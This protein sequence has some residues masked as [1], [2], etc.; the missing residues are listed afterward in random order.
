M[1]TL[2]IRIAV[3]SGV[4]TIAAAT[5]AATPAPPRAALPQPAPPAEPDPQPPPPAEMYR[6]ECGSCHLAYP[7][8]LLPAASWRRL[9]GGLEEHFGDNAELDASAR[10]RL[11][12]WLTNNSAQ[13][14][15]DKRGRK[16]VRTL[17]EP[18]PLRVSQT[19]YILRKHKKVKDEVFERPSVGGRANCV[20]CHVDAERGDFDDDRVKIPR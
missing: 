17:D 3:V 14:G 11:V 1:K 19:P 10:T 13:S 7:P 2:I 9:L 12:G 18:A 4:I 20:A 5:L 8:G 15:G 16:I 6:A